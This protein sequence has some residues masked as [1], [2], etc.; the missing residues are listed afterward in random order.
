MKSA[1]HHIVESMDQERI[2]EAFENKM[3]IFTDNNEDNFFTLAIRSMNVK[4]I[5][6]TMKYLSQIPEE[7]FVDI[8]ESIPL[9]YI[10]R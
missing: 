2:A 8:A 1:L 5:L 6:G 4:K 7:E 3:K 10:L 9:N